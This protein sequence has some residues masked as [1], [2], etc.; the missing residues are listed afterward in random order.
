MFGAGFIC[1]WLTWHLQ[2]LRCPATPFLYGSGQTAMIFVIL[3]L[4]F[5]SMG[6]GFLM[7]ALTARLVPQLR[8]FFGG[9]RGYRKSQHS[10]LRLFAGMFCV[11]LLLGM[12]ASLSQFCLL[13]AAIY[14]KRLP[15]SG[16][17]HYDWSDVTAVETAC[18][19]GRR[20]GWNGSFSLV[21]KDGN[22]FDILAW[23]R[24][25]IAS[26]PRITRAL[27]GVEFSFDASGTPRNCGAYYADLLWRRP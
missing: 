14:Y 20:G 3:P 1:L 26:Y 11:L 18:T 27:A 5:A 16:M 24:A 19:R 13:D 8:F 17:Q 15:W 23:P 22:R 7:I 10:Y 9:E 21:L 25:F 2:L 4:I 12:A 6:F